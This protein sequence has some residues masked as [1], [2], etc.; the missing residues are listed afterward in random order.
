MAHAAARIA[1]DDVNQFLNGV[2]AIAHHMAGHALGHCHRLPVDDEHT[3]V[4]AGDELLDDDITTMLLRLLEGQAHLGLAPQIERDP[5]AVAGVQRFD[6]HREPDVVRGRGRRVFLAHDALARHRD[7]DIVEQARGQLLVLRNVHGNV[8]RLARH[9]GLDALLVFA[10]PE[11]DQAAF[12][13]ANPRDVAHL[14]GLDQAARGWPQ[15]DAIGQARQLFQFQGEVESRAFRRGQRARQVIRQ[16]ATQQ[17]LGQAPGLQPH[18]FLLERVDHVVD[19]DLA[20]AARLT[21]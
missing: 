13:E 15:R 19:A 4:V 8:A 21:V 12:V 5:A 9:R 14:R 2:H 10:M 1:V 7:A 6:H 16:Q 11:L 20:G 18:F 17:A 3:I